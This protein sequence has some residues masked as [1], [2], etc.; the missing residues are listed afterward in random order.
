MFRASCTDSPWVTT[1]HSATVQNYNGTEQGGGGMMASRNSIA[2]F[3][4][5]LTQFLH[6]HVISISN[7]PCHFPTSKANE[8]VGMQ[9]EIAVA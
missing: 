6:S 9:S 7:V 1:I 5:P 2:Q 4:T 3:A 8:E